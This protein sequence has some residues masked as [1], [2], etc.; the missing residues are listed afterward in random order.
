MHFDDHKMVWIARDTLQHSS[1]VKVAHR[2]E[3]ID[4]HCNG[5]CKECILFLLEFLL[6]V[7]LEDAAVVCVLRSP[8]CSADLFPGFHA[9]FGVL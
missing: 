8:I 3:K 6:A 5:I 9:S 1:N 2:A 7:N 4:D